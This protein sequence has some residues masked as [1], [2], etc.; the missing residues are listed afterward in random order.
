MTIQNYSYW[1]HI[2]DIFYRKLKNV[3][4]QNLLAFMLREAQQQ[5]DNEQDFYVSFFLGSPA[6]VNTTHGAY[7]VSRENLWACVCLRERER[8]VFLSIL[9]KRQENNMLEVH[10]KK[11]LPEKSFWNWTKLPLLRMTFLTTDAFTHQWRKN[12][13]LIQTVFR[14][15]PSYII[16]PHYH[17]IN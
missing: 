15:P 10:D 2:S 12:K 8:N 7:Q 16:V 5:M 1:N 17:K 4:M 3:S 6:V 14:K 9:W 11:I 13:G